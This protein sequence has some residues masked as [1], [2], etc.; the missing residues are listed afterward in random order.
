MRY[1]LNS[2]VITSP[3][4]YHYRHI[5]PEEAKAWYQ[6]GEV[7]STIGYAETA[8]ALSQILH[9][10]VSVSRVSIRMEH[11]DEALVFRLAL[12]PG[13]PRIDPGDKGR[14]REAVIAGHWELGLLH[15]VE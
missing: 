10:P 11:G 2:A 5:S 1:L 13:T 7:Q 9:Q 4:L 3:G 8:E 12:P 15:R 6:A 14:L